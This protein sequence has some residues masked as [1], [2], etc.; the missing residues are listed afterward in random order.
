MDC[1]TIYKRVACLIAVFIWGSDKSIRCSQSRVYQPK[2]T[3]WGVG[4]GL[5]LEQ[6]NL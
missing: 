3:I 5:G 4:E 6:D 2:K 1:E